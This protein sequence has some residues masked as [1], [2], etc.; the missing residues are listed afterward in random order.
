[1]ARFCG[2]FAIRTTLGPRV[3]SS[4]L[5]RLNA[6]K[7]GALSTLMVWVLRLS[8]PDDHLKDVDD[9]VEVCR[10]AGLFCRGK[11][12]FFIQARSSTV[13]VSLWRS[14]TALIAP[15]KNSDADVHV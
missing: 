15:P 3:S 13:R 4:M 10:C 9:W 2:V 1:M 12:I 7:M 14:T 11:R 6:K 8:D 5:A